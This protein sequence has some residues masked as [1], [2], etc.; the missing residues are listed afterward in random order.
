[1]I[2]EDDNGFSFLFPID[3]DEAEYFS[4]EDLMDTEVTS[5]VVEEEQDTAETG[6]SVPVMPKYLRCAGSSSTC[7]PFQQQQYG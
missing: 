3:L 5:S 1:M 6:R 7:L 4:A 2:F